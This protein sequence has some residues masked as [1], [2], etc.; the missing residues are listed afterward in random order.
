MKVGF[1]PASGESFLGR[2]A[3]EHVVSLDHFSGEVAQPDR[4]GAV[5]A[6]VRG[7]HYASEGKRGFT[8][9]LPVIIFK[10]L[11]LAHLHNLSERDVERCCLENIPARLFPDVSR[12]VLKA[13][14]AA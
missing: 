8:A 5:P 4:L 9:C 11:L 6:A 3:Y 10:M 12:D 14:V 2:F 7:S 13:A 1:R